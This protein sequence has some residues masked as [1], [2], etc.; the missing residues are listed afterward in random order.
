MYLLLSASRAMYPK[1]HLA[2]VFRGSSNVH[3]R[4]T[5][6]TRGGQ[7]GVPSLPAIYPRDFVRR[8]NR[9]SQ[10]I[11]G[12]TEDLIQRP[13]KHHQHTLHRSAYPQGL[14][15]ALLHIAR[16]FWCCGIPV[17]SHIIRLPPYDNR[18]IGIFCLSAP[19]VGEHFH[20]Y[21]GVRL[22]LPWFA[23]VPMKGGFIRPTFP[24]RRRQ[25]YL[26]AH[27]R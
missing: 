8:P 27:M 20:W 16:M 10:G 12:K 24:D 11:D 25:G 7:P 9:R 18:E 1:L 2:F 19:S 17:S 22:G 6:V 15:L 21:V 13:H 3:S 14:Q 26:P 23:L 5:D 4:G